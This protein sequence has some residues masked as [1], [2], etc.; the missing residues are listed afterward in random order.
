MADEKMQLVSGRFGHPP[1]KTTC[2]ECPL[3]RDSTSGVLGGWTPE[4]Y[5]EGLVGPADFACHMSKG[6]LPKDHEATRSCTGVANFRCNSGIAR[7]LLP[8]GNALDACVAAG[9]DH[10]QVFSTLREFYDHHT[11]AK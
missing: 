10:V 11:K 7:T 1:A 2:N 9:P 8:R 4:M 6:F 3:R 5:V